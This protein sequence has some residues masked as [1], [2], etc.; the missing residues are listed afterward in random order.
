[1]SRRAKVPRSS[2]NAQN[3]TEKWALLSW[4]DLEK[5]AGS[6]S[7]SRGRSYQRQ[8]R[9]T[10][11]SIA[12][13]GRLLATVHGNERYVTSAW[14]VSGRG[15][16]K[17]LESICSCPVGTSGCKH[18][19]AVVADLLSATADGRQVPTAQP[20]DRR[21][22]ALAD[23]HDEDFDSLDDDDD[24]SPAERRRGSSRGNGSDWDRRIRE[25]VEK[26]SHAELV[27]FVQTLVGRFPELRQEIQERIELAEGNADRLLAAA[28]RELRSVT[29]EHGWSN[30]WNGE[31]HCPDYS[32]L[33]HK[34]ERLTELG[35]ADKVV[36]LGRELIDRGCEQVGHSD[37]EG[38]T[39]A[40]LA[41]CL[42]VVFDAVAKS[43][44]SAAEKILYAIDACLQ[45][46]Y[47]ILGE[48]V[49][50]LLNAKW[51]KADWLVV[52]DRL[53]ARL[54]ES[55]SSDSRDG[56]SRDYNRDRLTNFLADALAH[57]GRS[58]ELTAVYEAE[59]LA[60]GSYQRYVD[61]LIEQKKID[62]AERWARQGIDATRIKYP[63]I[64]ARLAQTMC[65]LAT[66]R[67]QWDVV[68]AHAAHEFFERPAAGTF[69]SLVA[70]AKRA[71]C[72][73]PVRVAAQQF[74][75]TGASPVRIAAN[76]KGSDKVKVDSSWPLPVPDYLLALM[77][78]SRRPYAAGPHLDVLLDMAIADKRPADVLHWFDEMTRGSKNSG[79]DQY[80]SYD[81][82]GRVA[83]AIAGTHPERAI[84]IYRQELER[85][86][87]HASTTAYENCVV[88]LRQMRP[89]FKQLDREDYWTELVADIRQQYRN[90]PRF[91]EMLERLAGRTIVQ[92]LKSSK[93]RK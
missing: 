71:G 8:G 15:K 12:E 55:P 17:E 89:I 79:P 16:R 64:A 81:I 53:S 28:R 65:D 10:D 88:C 51:S 36:D 35:H 23:D 24:P 6:R 43:S 13:D 86:L 1:M 57:A 27:T 22:A 4:D 14:L 18:A 7:V 78:N 39:A 19:V 74:L 50:N 66:R 92:T 21:W 87:P 38:E 60:T 5:W 61:Y 2:S 11:L 54:R 63:G 52:A 72:E 85:Q 42:Q 80:Y 32:R 93:R 90:R 9:V 29:T 67:K 91:M 82:S 84:E 20:D 68:A 77:D 58:G 45:D 69:K 62:E 83:K 37:D 48:G 70:A 26:Q 59:A 34:L 3:A 76:G 47:D 75:E 56:F 73:E 46:D 31:G 33:K 25:H 44:L 30:H 40:A 49:D 41:D